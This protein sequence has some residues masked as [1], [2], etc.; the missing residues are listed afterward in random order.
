MQLKFI[1]IKALTKRN[2]GLLRG[3]ETLVSALGVLTAAL[4]A[5]AEDL[6]G[7]IHAGVPQVFSGCFFDNLVS[8]EN[9]PSDG[10]RCLSSFP[11]FASVHSAP[12]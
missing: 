2:P 5:A 9:K 4:G 8:C 6:F 3:A 1:N 10:S 12:P 7:K 11:K